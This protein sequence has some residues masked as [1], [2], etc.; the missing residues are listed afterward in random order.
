M[1]SVS[2]VA[3]TGG[4]GRIG[5]WWSADGF[6][7]GETPSASARVEW[8]L[9]RVFVLIRGATLVQTAVAAGLMWGRFRYGAVV[10]VLL[11][12]AAVESA[13]VVEVCRRRGDF[14]DARPAAAA[15]LCVTVV[16]V[17]VTAVALRPSTDPY[18]DLV[19]YPYSVASMTLAGF[20][21]RRL[22]G[23]ALS[24]ALA[25]G[26]Y[27]GVVLGRFTFQ[28][29]LLTN[30]A[31]YW[32]W[33]VV[34]FAVTSA[35]RR[36]S[37]SL[38]QARRAEVQL[39]RQQQWTEIS[40]ELHDHALQALEVVTQDGWVADG[41][42]RGLLISVAARLRSWLEGTLDGGPDDLVAG[43]GAVLRE[44][45]ASGLRVRLYKEAMTDPVV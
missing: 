20:S 4:M 3:Q 12:V 25:S 24:A 10:V 27:V 29:G 34:A 32:G 18:L 41:Q 31:T 35:L 21:A 30:A 44:Q 7:G 39:V 15:D 9:W 14:R 6:G 5:R 23:A 11:V 26:S 43:L 42:M 40:R 38:D 13:A 45:A 16:A 33:V 19:F 28:A 2:V 8:L 17:V 22:P 1:Q 37:V 36:M